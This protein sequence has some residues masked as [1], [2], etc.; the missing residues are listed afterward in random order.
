V[1]PAT[2]RFLLDTNILLHLVRGGINSTPL[3]AE[4]EARFDLFTGR[5]RVFLSYVTVGEIRVI[6][7]KN[8]WGADKWTELNR[9][10]GGFQVV[11][12]TGPELLDAYVS[13]DTYSHYLG[14]EV[15]SK[16]DLWIAATAHVYGLT[17]ITTD[18]DIDHLGG[19]YFP[20]SYLDPAI[21]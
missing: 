19:E 9:L 10:L 13:V 20:L 7:E 16:N 3:I 12:L 21:A 14:R 8:H 18:K 15:G 6:G 5:N 1:I 17:L 11:P 2:Q 4:L